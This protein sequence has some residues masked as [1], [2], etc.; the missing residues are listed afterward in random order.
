MRNKIRGGKGRLALLL[1]AFTVL[2]VAGCQSVGGLDL[3]SMLHNALKVKSVESNFTIELNLDLNE[4]ALTKQF[5]EEEAELYRLFSLIK[6]EVKNAKLENESRL[7]LDGRLILGEQS[8]FDIAFNLN[9]NGSTVVLYLEGAKQPFTIV[10]SD[11]PLFDTSDYPS[12]EV[13]QA[14]KIANAYTMTKL[15]FNTVD[16]FGGYLFNNLPNTKD[17]KLQTANVPI[18]GMNTSL[19]HVQ[20]E[21]N[22]SQL[23]SWFES[24]V[25]A[26]ATDKVGAEK[27]V[28]GIVDV[29]ASNPEFKELAEEMGLI[30]PTGVDETTRD[31]II[32]EWIDRIYELT[33]ELQTEITTLNMEYETGEAN[34][35]YYSRNALFAKSLM[36]TQT[37][38]LQL[39][40]DM[41]VDNKLDVRKQQLHLNYK[42][43]AGL[44]D[45]LPPIAGFTLTASQE[46][47]NIN[48]TV[49]ADVLASVPNAISFEKASLME[50]YQA[51][52]L[53]DEKSDVY[54]LLKNK[55]HITRQ[56][57]QVYNHQYHNP[58][59]ILP[60]SIAIVSVRDVANAFGAT[61]TYDPKTKTV[62]IY[63]E[64]TDTTIQ[65]EKGSKTVMVNGEKQTW[66]VAVTTVDGSTYVAARK[67]AEALEASI[68][69]H[70]INLRDLSYYDPSQYDPSMFEPLMSKEVVIYR[71]L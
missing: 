67:L 52:K 22:G 16:H 59:I 24:Y 61:T 60:G 28:I 55:F 66:P 1:L 19:M 63:D 7:S 56:F 9:M 49:K 71:E 20:L 58:L 14:A 3:N 18:N 40:L 48:G 47:W 15:G 65:L 38:S 30:G 69:W 50:G 39:K 35:D 32:E 70:Q 21:M 10:L 17:L 64:A 36:D 4:D 51:V 23:W 34:E 37:E 12:E 68:Y 13:Q 25:N 5:S 54:H 53:F 26:L 33:D 6:L 27:M 11:I 46:R 41:Y 29:M 2:F 62:V 8:E 43:G 57:Y 31:E 42:V 44:E 45:Y